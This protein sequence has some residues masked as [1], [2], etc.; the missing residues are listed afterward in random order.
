MPPSDVRL[1]RLP[2]RWLPVEED[3]ARGKGALL[4]APAFQ[5][6]RIEH[7]SCYI[8]YPGDILRSFPFKHPE[9]YVS[10]NPALFANVRDF[11]STS[12]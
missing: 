4:E 1:V 11:S 3:T 9:G 8:S 6:T 5:R 7:V 12:P 2:R 10:S